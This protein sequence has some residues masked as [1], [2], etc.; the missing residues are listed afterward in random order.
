MQPAECRQ[1]GSA[2][3]HRAVR[4][5]IPVSVKHGYMKWQQEKLRV[6][7]GMHL[8]RSLGFQKPETGETTAE[9]IPEPDHGKLFKTSKQGAL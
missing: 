5:G 1:A 4:V 3:S 7:L 6:D 8:S 9:R 2:G